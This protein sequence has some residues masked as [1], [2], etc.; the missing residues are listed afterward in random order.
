MNI[1]NIQ[2]LYIGV[3][4]FDMISDSSLIKF[5]YLENGIYYLI[6]IENDILSLILC[7]N[8]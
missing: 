7:P 2:S 5:N 3:F 1:C 8:R 6:F 4:E